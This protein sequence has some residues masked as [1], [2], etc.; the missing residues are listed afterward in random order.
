MQRVLVTGASGFVGR[1]V[2]EHL[3]CAGKVVVCGTRNPKKSN[4]I[5]SPALGYGAD[6]R[7]CLR[8]CDG[9]IHAAARVHVM[10]EHVADPL[11]E[12]RKANVDGTLRL[13]RQASEM[14]VRRFVF[15]SSV[16]VNGE[17]TNP[18]V[19]FR[20]EDMPAPEDPY[21][22]SKAEAEAGLFA[23][24]R[25]TDMEVVVVR[26]PLVYGPGVK[27]NFETM[28]RWLRTGVPLPLGAIDYNRRSF[29]GVDNLA[30]LLVTCLDHPAAA[31]QVF[32]AGDG[33]DLSTVDL[34]RRLAEAMHC[35]LRLYRC[36]PALLRLVANGVGKKSWVERLCG[37]LQVDISKARDC[38]GWRPGSSV[39][40][41]LRRTVAQFV[42]C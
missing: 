12:Y 33:E 26:P 39:D 10:D 16:K 9:V 11:A 1:A 24:S 34:L 8:G 6:W 2:T 4:D 32:L 42:R 35:P 37:N 13:A 41:G 23:L 5:Q 38:L 29:V 7:E 31:N 40:E 27:A 15:V 3:T 17:V 21:G 20:E 14:G 25:E 28:V 19:A 30:E 36:P 22:I 18:G